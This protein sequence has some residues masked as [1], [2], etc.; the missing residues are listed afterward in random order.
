MKNEELINKL[1][2]A[3]GRIENKMSSV[4][5]LTYDT[6]NNPRASVKYIYDLALILN[7]N[8][9]FTM[10]TKLRISNRSRKINTTEVKFKY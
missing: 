6:K 10:L 1:F 7:K 3:L 8:F 2:D 9:T 5:F 4:Y